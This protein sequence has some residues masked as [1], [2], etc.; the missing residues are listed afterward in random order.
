MLN[1]FQKLNEV[2]II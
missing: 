1:D 2:N